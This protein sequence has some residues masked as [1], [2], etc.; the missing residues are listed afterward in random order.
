MTINFVK[1]AEVT[2]DILRQALIFAEGLLFTATSYI[3]QTTGNSLSTNDVAE[4]IKVH[5]LEKLYIDLQADL[6][7]KIEEELIRKIFDP[8]SKQSVSAATTILKKKF[9]WNETR[10]LN[11]KTDEKRTNSKSLSGLT[12]SELE[13]LHKLTKK[14][15]DEC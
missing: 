2:P 10:N 12:D 3:N 11:V 5:S 8:T 4:L 1:P 6:E 14:V 7:R 13:E 9:G 15:V